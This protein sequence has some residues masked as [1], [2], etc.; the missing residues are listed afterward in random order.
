VT[1]YV[2]GAISGAPANN[3]GT[4]TSGTD[5]LTIGITKPFSSNTFYGYIDEVKIWS[6]VRTA[7]QIAQSRFVGLGDYASAN[8]GNA[9]TSADNYTGLLSSWTMNNNTRDDIGGKNGFTRNGAGLYWYPYTAGYPIPYNFALYRPSASTTS[10]VTVPSNTAFDLTTA[11]TIEYWFNTS[12]ATSTQWTISKGV[13]AS[14]MWG[15]GI[16]STGFMVLRLGVNPV[17]NTGGIP[18]P[19]NKWVH[20]AF[21]WTGTSGNYTTKYYVNGQQSGANTPNTGALST[22]TD[23]LCIGLLQPFNGF[24][25]LGYVD[26]V[27][28]WNVERTKQQIQ[29]NMFASCRSILPNTNLKGAWNFDG[30]LKNFSATTGIDGSFSTGGANTCRLS[31]YSNEST[32]GPAPNVQFIAHPTVFN[33]A[34]Y[35]AGFTKKTLNTAIP[36]NAS[37]T[38]TIYMT[39]VPGN[40]LDIQVFLAI[41]HQKVSDLTIKLKAP[42]ATEIILDAA[43]GTTSANG[44]LTIMDDTTGNAINGTTYLAPWTQYVKPSN[45]MGTFGN[46]PIN[47]NWVLTITDGAATNTGTLLSWGIRFNNSILV[48]YNNTSGNI[49]GKFNLEQNYPNPFNPVTKIKFEVPSSELVKLV[50]YDLLGRKVKTIVNERMNAGIYEYE[51]DGSS[52]S[53]GIYFCK[54][55]AGSFTSIKKMILIK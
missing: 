8:T 27:R 6:T 45:P 2:N 48:N 31:A 29:D 7:A 14:N 16:A 28:V 18:I 3:T 33:S 15:V 30:N 24:G 55:E 25:L 13:S 22:N 36:D 10:F 53:S 43:Q 42:N 52:L 23:P 5:S 50:V 44:M 19:A 12:S 54:M 11:G 51:F 17:I 9:L 4:M 32:T 38:D 46:S 40:V 21:T 34:G 49:P 35:P 47:G 39:Y 20:L 41:Q 1:F 37:L 26:E